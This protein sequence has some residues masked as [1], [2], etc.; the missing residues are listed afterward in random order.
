MLCLPPTFIEKIRP[1]CK[2]MTRFVHTRS[3]NPVRVFKQHRMKKYV[4]GQQSRS[5]VR[6]GCYDASDINGKETNADE[7]E[8]EDADDGP[9]HLR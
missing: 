3:P 6:R 1:F 4:K 9:Q 5:L 2:A 7:E 8:K